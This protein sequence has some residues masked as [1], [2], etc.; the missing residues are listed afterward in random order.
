VDLDRSSCPDEEGS[1]VSS[2]R[3]TAF[4]AGLWFLGTFAFS[5]PAGLLYDPVLKDAGHIL[6]AGADKRIEIGAFFEVLLAIANVA[7]AVV[8][9]QILRRVHE[10]VALGFKGFRP[11][12][13]LAN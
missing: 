13:I 10:A 9:F 8:L 1:A 7:T 5:I 4:Y 11:S 6:G 2:A 12:P 3:R